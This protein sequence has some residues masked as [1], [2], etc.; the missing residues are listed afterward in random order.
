MVSQFEINN[1]SVYWRTPSELVVPDG[2]WQEC[3]G[4]P[5]GISEALDL[6]DLNELLHISKDNLKIFKIQMLQMITISPI[7]LENQS[8]RKSDMIEIN[9]RIDHI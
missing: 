6:D 7:H 9:L 5:M 4:R 8:D 2:L 3:A 1:A